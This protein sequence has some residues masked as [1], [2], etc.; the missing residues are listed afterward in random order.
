MPTFS[1]RFLKMSQEA[2]GPAALY[3]RKAIIGE[4][5]LKG[6]LTKGDKTVVT[7]VDKKSQALSS[8]FIRKAFPEAR[9]NQEEAELETGNKDAR[10]TIYHD[11]LDGTG[12]FLVGGSTPTIILAAYDNLAKEF[13]AV[14]TMEPSTGRFWF[15]AKG[16]GAWEYVYDY[17]ASKWKSGRTRMQVNKQ[18]IGD[19]AIV[20]VDLSFPFK[21]SMPDGSKKWMLMSKGRGQFSDAVQSMGMKEYSFQTNGV[22]YALTALG[23]PQLVAN[24]ST[25][26]GGPYDVAGMLHVQEAGGYIASLRV[27]ET[28]KKRKLVVMKDHDMAKAEMCIAANSKKTF[29]KLFAAMDVAVRAN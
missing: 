8:P 26:M 1:Q 5:D 4:V 17:A 2:L 7:V 25:A 28:G 14:S 10:I 15:S 23:R 3:I 20:L 9:I 21:R 11:P 22:H 19:G 24:I 12:G 18:Q 13:I 16:E 29:D 6:Y 27:E